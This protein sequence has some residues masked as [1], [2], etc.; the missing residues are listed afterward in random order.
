MKRNPAWF[1][2]GLIALIGVAAVSV[3]TDNLYIQNSE[4]DQVKIR[5][6]TA[7]TQTAPW[8]EFNNDGTLAFSL[9]ATGIIPTTY[10]G[11]GGATPAAA[12]A[13]LGVVEGATN[14]TALGWRTYIGVSEFTTNTLVPIASGGTASATAAA[15]KLA[16]G[17]QSGTNILAADHTVTN[18][19]GTAFSAAPIVTVTG[20]TQGPDTNAFILSVS[21]TNVIV[22]GTATDPIHWIAVGAP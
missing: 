11:T 21:T 14:T 3:S 5:V 6:R 1:L 20:W 7:D 2:L 22:A 8:I 13:S 10:G 19:F 4:V 12:R 16:F 15:A 18:T 17:I 9:P